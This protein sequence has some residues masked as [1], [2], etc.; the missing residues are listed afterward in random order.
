VGRG[1]V[2][3]LIGHRPRT[4]FCYAFRMRLLR[5]PRTVG[6]LLAFTAVGCAS[7]VERAPRVLAVSPP[8]LTVRADFPSPGLTRVLVLREWKRDLE[9]D[10][11]LRF[12]PGIHRAGVDGD[13]GILLW[14]LAAWG[15]VFVVTAVG[16]VCYLIGKAVWTVVKPA[17]GPE[18]VIRFEETLR[19]P[20]L[21]ATV[22]RWSGGPVID[23]GIQPVEG[24]V[25]SEDTLQSLGGPGTEVI[26]RD[27]ELSAFYMLPAPR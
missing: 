11:A 2:A 19:E 23:L 13:V 25:L 9:Q 22:E 6:L 18:K 24:Y 1:E 15:A 16:G 4:E 14:Y 7:R 21:R 12:G 3:V 26:F 5:T 17:P 10:A 8:T 27:G 20:V